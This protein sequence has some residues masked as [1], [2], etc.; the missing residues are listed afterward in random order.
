MRLYQ[1][2]YL[3]SVFIVLIAFSVFAEE[4]QVITHLENELQNRLQ[5]AKSNPLQKNFLSQLD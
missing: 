4:R 2:Y 5:E 1:N 3:L